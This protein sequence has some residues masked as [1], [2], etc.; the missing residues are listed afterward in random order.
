MAKVHLLADIRAIFDQLAV[1]RLA[2][3]TLVAELA[4]D[5]DGPWASYGRTSKPVTQRQVATLLSDFATPSG[6]KI[7]PH[8][9][10][11]EGKITKGYAR[12]QFVDAFERYLSPASPAP[13][14]QSA[15]P[16]QPNEIND[17]QGKPCATPCLL[18]ADE[19]VANR[20]KSNGCSGVADRAPCLDGKADRTC[21]QCRG[22]VDGKERQVATGHKTVWLHPECERFY[23]GLGKLS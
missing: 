4:K 15:T 14:F 16:L 9:I 2:S 3:A 6:T 18:V 22:V 10:R 8:N 12:E 20:L 17:L 19:N 13:L 11:A 7:K 23:L 1:D 21:V 5:A